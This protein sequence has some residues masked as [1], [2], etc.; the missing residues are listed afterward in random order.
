MKRIF[1]VVALTTVLAIGGH[2]VWAQ[3]F[4]KGLAAAR[5]G[6]FETALREWRPLAEQGDARAQRSLG[7]MYLKGEGVPQDDAEA[8]KWYRLAAKQGHADAQYNLG[9]KYGS[10]EGVLQDDA[11]AA[12]WYRL[13]AEQGH[14]QAQNILGQLYRKGTARD[15][16]M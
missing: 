10:G 2:A 14:A 6:D 15:M 1:H 8:V 5:A 9:V 13:A 3:D 7:I 11:E 4:D 16:K 12:K